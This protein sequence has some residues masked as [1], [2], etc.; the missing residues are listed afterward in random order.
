MGI[1]GKSH[2]HAAHVHVPAL[3]AMAWHVHVAVIHPEMVHMV[4]VRV[5][6]LFYTIFII[7]E[8]ER[9]S[10]SIGVSRSSG[11]ER[12]KGESSKRGSG[13]V[14][15]H[16]GNNKAHS[17]V[18]NLNIIEKNANKKIVVV[19]GLFGLYTNRGSTKLRRCEGR[20]LSPRNLL[21]LAQ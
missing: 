8:E 5:I 2:I 13:R 18:A 20:A 14:Y 19:A 4:V 12:S 9:M 6:H 11:S 21:K 17:V 15:F 3:V 10:R 16:L 1:P 7:F